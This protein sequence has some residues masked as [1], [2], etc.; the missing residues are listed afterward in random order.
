MP[1]KPTRAFV[2]EIRRVTKRANGMITTNTLLEEEIDGD[3]VDELIERF[4]IDED[5]L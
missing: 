3:T 1:R 4:R 5:E 2:I